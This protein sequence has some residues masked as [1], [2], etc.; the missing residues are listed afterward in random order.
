MR[1]LRKRS[2]LLVILVL[3]AEQNNT[4]DIMWLIAEEQHTEHLAN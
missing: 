3:Q 2:N 4:F 1:Q